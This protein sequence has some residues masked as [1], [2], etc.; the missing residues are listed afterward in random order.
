MSAAPESARGVDLKLGRWALAILPAVA[1]WLLPIPEGITPAGWRLLA[2]FIATIL[3][4]ITRPMPGGAVVLL[5]V[6]AAAVTGALPVEQALRGYSDPVVW[7]V[8]AAFC[9]SRSM[10]STGLGRRVALLF[11][12]AL[13]KNSLGLGYALVSTDWVLASAIPSN[14][15]RS[16]G[17]LFPIARSIAETYDSRP[18]DTAKRLGAF[19]MILLYQCDVV[20]CAMFLTGQASNPLIAKLGQQTTGWTLDYST[21]LLA[22]LVPGLVS[23]L[24]VPWM[25]YKLYPPELK[26][27]PEASAFAARELDRMGP[28][29]SR[30][31]IML[32]VFGLVAVL[33]MTTAF[34]HV[35]YAVVALL[36]VAV[37]L[38]SGVLTWEEVIT[39]RS[40]WDVFIWYGGL[41]RLALALGEAGITRK[42]AERAGSLTTGWPWWIALTVLCL[43]YFFAHYGFA[44]ITAHATSMLTPFLLVVMVAGAPPHL[45]LL[46]L[47][48]LSNLCASLTHYGTTPGPIYFGAGYVSQATWWRLGLMVA[49][50]NLAIWTALGPLWWRVIGFW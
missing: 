7:L 14:G 43:I 37:L 47:A 39:E 29:S 3:G 9:I 46:L 13:G 21:W 26:E 50:V 20:V 8:L 16:G 19:L 32:L 35:D 41:V 6:T 28:P 45:A 42:F 4:S 12:R 49:L 30:E 23:M 17:I 2:V 18:G 27:T 40:A 24:V 22:A 10:I 5:G 31:R 36:G 48:F 15:A 33:W 44:S 25:L 11:I 34:H 1:V 38:L